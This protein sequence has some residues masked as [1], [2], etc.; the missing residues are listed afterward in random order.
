MA[1]ADLFIE[2]SDIATAWALA[3]LHVASQPGRE[4]QP[5]IVRIDAAT[6]VRQHV[7][8][9]AIANRLLDGW[10]KNSVDTVASTIFPYSLW[11]RGQPASELFDRYERIWPHIRKARA[12]TNGTYFRRLTA[13]ESDRGQVN[14]LA[15]VVATWKKGNHRRS[16][17][18]LAVFDPTRDHT[19]Q[20]QRGFPCLH[21]V[22]VV[23][24]SDGTVSLTAF[25]AMQL[26]LEK[27]YGNYLGL[28]HLGEFVAEAL[29]MRL[30]TVT[31]IA[32][33]AKL[34]QSSKLDEAAR[35]AL[36]AEIR[37]ELKAP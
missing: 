14:Q 27:A 1:T 22:A 17:L 21:Q 28:V 33:V 20:R 19:D 12:N 10:S 34:T 7:G 3:T 5:L 30:A 13:F 8:I 18:Q 4:A 25:Y 24:H 16:A 15:Q 6:G 37:Q 31:C 32:S 29:G 11:R 35:A 23:P 9:R 26:V 2:S 36:V